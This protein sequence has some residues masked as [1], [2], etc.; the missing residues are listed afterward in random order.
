MARGLLAL[1]L[2]VIGIANGLTRRG[3]GPLID[4]HRP[5]DT[6]IRGDG[7]RKEIAAARARQQATE[8]PSPDHDHEVPDPQPTPRAASGPRRA[9]YGAARHRPTRSGRD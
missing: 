7:V 8:A 4:W 2:L 3:R 6:P 9:T 1:A 5:R